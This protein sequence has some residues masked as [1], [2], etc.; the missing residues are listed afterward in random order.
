MQPKEAA[1]KACAGSFSWAERRTGLILNALAELV[2]DP[3]LSAGAPPT[4][5]SCQKWKDWWAKNRDKAVFVIRR[6]HPT[7]GTN[8]YGRLNQ[9]AAQREVLDTRREQHMDSEWTW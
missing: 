6:V 1:Q 4:A 5:E 8:R 9:S 2:K 7:I 3:P